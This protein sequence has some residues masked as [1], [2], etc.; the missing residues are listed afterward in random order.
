MAIRVAGEDSFEVQE[1]P[2]ILQFVS[3]DPD[4][5]ETRRGSLGPWAPGPLHLP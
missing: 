1:K 5:V 2:M 3:Q 4:A